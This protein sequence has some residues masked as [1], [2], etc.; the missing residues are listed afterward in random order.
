MLKNSDIHI[1]DPFVLPVEAEQQYYLYGTTG[2]E[3][4]TNHATGLDYYTGRDLEHWE[5]PFPA[6]RP[7]AGFWADRNYWAPEVHAFRGK[8]YMF[9]TFKSEGAR[10]GTQILA[11]DSPRGPF[12][13]ISE[14]PVTP[15]EWECLDG[16]LFVDDDDQPWMVFCHEW[17]QVGDGE[18]CALR[19]STDLTAA[20]GE[21][22]LLTRASEAAWAEELVSK[23]R[24]GYVTDGPSMYRLAN[25]ELVMLWSSFRGGR[26]GVG[27]AKSASGG[28]AGPWV[29]VAEPLYEAD[30]G[31]CMVFKT[32]EGELRLAFHRPNPNP[33]ERPQFVALRENGGGLE[34]SGQ[35]PHP[36]PL[37][38]RRGEKRSERSEK[39]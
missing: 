21:P 4:W 33:Q 11:A 16:T 17:V 13:P 23:N 15:R 6:F 24:R 10:R 20:V 30:G 25:G 28:I 14:G 1:R 26:Y 27:V 34:I 39:K 12:R 18:I 2:A 36:R 9:V 29:H 8:Y 31:H 19:L 38:E 35:Q 5:G 22:M 7:E 32:F 3:A 37:S